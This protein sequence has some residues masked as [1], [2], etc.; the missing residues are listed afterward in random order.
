MVPKATG[1][2]MGYKRDGKKLLYDETEWGK[3]CRE[4][5]ELI[6]ASGLPELVVSDEDH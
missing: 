1:K 4:H 2:T 3:W 6:K 5:A